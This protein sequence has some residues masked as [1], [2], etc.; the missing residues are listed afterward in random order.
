MCLNLHI[1]SL[2]ICISHPLIHI[3]NA[4]VNQTLAPPTFL[5]SDY[6]LSTWTIHPPS[7]KDIHPVVY[8]MG[9]G[10]CDITMETYKWNMTEWMLLITW[11]EIKWRGIKLWNVSGI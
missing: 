2:H 4:T 7:Y 5:S 9:V 10:E 3:L 1:V 8:V 11:K 6:P